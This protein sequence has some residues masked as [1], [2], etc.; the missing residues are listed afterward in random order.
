MSA[1]WV[2]SSKWLTQ[3]YSTKIQILSCIWSPDSKS[4]NCLLFSIKLLYMP[5]VTPSCFP[6]VPSMPWIV[7][8]L[9]W[10]DQPLWYQLGIHGN[11]NMNSKD[12]DLSLF[13]SSKA[14]VSRKIL[15]SFAYSHTNFQRCLCYPSCFYSY[16]EE[17]QDYTTI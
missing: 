12:Q 3:W 1:F 13:E 6:S 11:K 8:L 4:L 14:F 10:E 7:S 16:V 15:P 5:F 2:I 9:S 17:L